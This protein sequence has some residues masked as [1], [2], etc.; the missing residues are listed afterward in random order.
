MAKR[1]AVVQS[2]YIPWR[3]Y[4][5]LIA[6]VDEFVLYDDVQYTKNDWRNRNRIVTGQGSRWLSI[7]VI[8]KGR[9]GQLIKDV[10]VVDGTW[11]SKHWKSIAHTY[12]SAPGF[13]EYGEQIEE[14][15]ATASSGFLSEINH[16]FL[17]SLMSMLGITTPLT[18][19]MDYKV[20]DGDRNRRLLGLLHATGATTYLSGPAAA[21][22]LDEDLFAAAGIS[23]V[24]A[25]YSGYPEYPQLSEP[26][27]PNVSIVDLLLMTGAGA[28][29]YL[30]HTTD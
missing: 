15:Y 17:S 12:G 7:P 16:H 5:D 2:N 14:L 6:A 28:R 18:W 21:A 9:F 29:N 26:F 4:F 19:S 3:G 1:V 20:A 27:D 10:C 30:K 22:Y 25:D 8:T 11:R 24:Y 23:V 13:G